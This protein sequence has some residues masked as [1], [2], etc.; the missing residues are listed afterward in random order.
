MHSSKSLPGGIKPYIG[1]W[2]HYPGTPGLEVAH[3]I[4]HLFYG[5][6]HVGEKARSALVRALNRSSLVPQPVAFTSSLMRAGDATREINRT[7]F[8]TAYG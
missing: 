5:L 4:G 7:R 1:D 6:G 8:G 3:E 2:D